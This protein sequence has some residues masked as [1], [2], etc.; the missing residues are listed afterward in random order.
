[1]YALGA[2]TLA[3][4]YEVVNTLPFSQQLEAMRIA[5]QMSDSYE[6]YIKSK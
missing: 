3:Q 2:C 4:W 6:Q 5:V 1:M